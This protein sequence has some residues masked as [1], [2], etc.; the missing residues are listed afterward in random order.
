M[1]K[2]CKK[3]KKTPHHQIQRKL[4]I[5]FNALDDDDIKGIF[6]D[7]ACFFMGMDVDY[8]SK[9]LDGCGFHSRIGIEV[10]MQRSL[11]TTNWYNKLRMHDLLRDMG[12]EIIREMSPDHPGKRRRLCFQ[13]DVLDALRKKMVRTKCYGEHKLTNA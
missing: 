5:S 1:E 9:L 6:L 8:V 13:K 3:L 11:I 2:C 4:Q 7:I 12:R 10:L